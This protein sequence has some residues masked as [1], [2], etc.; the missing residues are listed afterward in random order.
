ME[1]EASREALRKELANMQRRMAELEDD[2][3]L[4]EKDYQMA[5]A[6]ANRTE[7]KLDDQRRNLEMSLESTSSELADVKLRLSGAE[8][9]VTALETE[10]AR[11]EGAKRDVEFKL[12]SIVSSLRRSIGFTQGMPRSRSPLRARSPSPRR[13]RP[14]SPT[15]GRNRR[16]VVILLPPKIHVNKHVRES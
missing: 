14:N 8:G 9:R 4:K 5:L 7:K 1:T 13:S 2:I 12:G 16:Q 10:V 3:R 11:V 6:D 15:K